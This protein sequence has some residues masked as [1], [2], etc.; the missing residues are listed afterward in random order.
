MEIPKMS[1]GPT[2]T[3]TIAL[4]VMRKENWGEFLVHQEGRGWHWLPNGES[5]WRHDR[6]GRRIR[7]EIRHRFGEEENGSGKFPIST[8]QAVSGVAQLAENDPHFWRDEIKWNADP[9]TVGLPDGGILNLETGEKVES[10]YVTKRLGAN[11]SMKAPHRWLRF[12]LQ[13]LHSKGDVRYLQRVMG[14]CLTGYTREHLFWHL[15]GAGRNG[16][17]VMLSIMQAALGEYHFRINADAMLADSKDGHAPHPEWL[18]SL[19]GHRLW[20]ADE[21][22]KNAWATHKLKQLVA[23]DTQ[24]AHFMRMDA[25]NFTPVGKLFMAGNDL[26]RIKGGANYSI[27]ERIK[28][29]DFPNSFDS[30]TRDRLLT[31]KLKNELP[32]IVGWMVQGAQAYIRDGLLPDTPDINRMGHRFLENSKLIDPVTKWIKR[33]IDYK[34]GAFTTNKEL[35]RSLKNEAGVVAKSVQGRTMRTLESEGLAVDVVVRAGRRRIDGVNARGVEGVAI[36]PIS[37]DR[38]FGPEFGE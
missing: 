10:G 17:G 9:K 6:R 37:V 30:D 24:N 21:L 28:L 8:S 12:L 11:P 35:L 38:Q 3:Q 25:F 13:V 7:N 1:K 26:P 31:D 5:V 18:A 14:Y 19:D 29:V 36:R 2:L 20:T 23:G 34:S 4:K 16:K 32:E 33:R 22:T 15:H 27:S